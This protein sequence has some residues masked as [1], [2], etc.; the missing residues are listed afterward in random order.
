ML[1][2]IVYN[3]FIISFA[4]LFCFLYKNES[5][6]LLY[7]HK[8]TIWPCMEYCYYVSIGTSW[9]ILGNL[10]QLS[11]DVCFQDAPDNLKILNKK[12]CKAYELFI[13]TNSRC[14]SFQLFQGINFATTCQLLSPQKIFQVYK[15]NSI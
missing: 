5:H 10:D 11:C 2:Y 1:F 9:R 8:S 14:Y 3:L 13:W 4:V 7:F 15:H 6:E 12:I